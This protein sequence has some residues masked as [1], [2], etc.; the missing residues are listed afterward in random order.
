MMGLIESCSGVAVVLS[1]DSCLL[2][3]VASGGDQDAE[4]GARLTCHIL[5]RL[6][7]TPQVS[8]GSSVDG[9]KSTLWVRASCD[10]HLL[11]AAH[12]SISVGAVVA[13]LKAGLM[14]GR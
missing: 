8:P 14:L 6:F 11:E 2:L 12:D 9:G 13:V 5:F 10:R 4:S 3:A 1:D 7:Q